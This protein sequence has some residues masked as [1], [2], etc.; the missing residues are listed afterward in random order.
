LR[1]GS[2]F[3]LIAHRD[4][5]MTSFFILLVLGSISYW[6]FTATTL[7]IFAYVRSTI[8]NMAFYSENVTFALLGLLVGLVALEAMLVL[9]AY[10]V[11]GWRGRTF[12]S[13]PKLRVPILRMLEWRGRLC[14][15]V[16]KIGTIF[17]MVVF[18]VPMVQALLIEQVYPHFFYPVQW[19]P[20]IELLALVFLF[21]ALDTLCA[22]PLL[23]HVVFSAR[24]KSADLIVGQ[25]RLLTMVRSE[26]KIDNYDWFYLVR[27]TRRYLQDFLERLYPSRAANLRSSLASFFFALSETDSS[28]GQESTS[29]VERI[30]DVVVSSDEPREALHRRIESMCEE[31]STFARTRSHGP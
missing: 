12:R 24:L 5:T 3:R 4:P 14:F 25:L 19:N 9:T 31:L 11:S 10:L 21:G 15:P 26:S 22:I 6:I 30:I 18:F 28:A 16:T 8:T 27:S 7:G 29:A 13:E 17:T 2:I 23:A 20:P 1:P